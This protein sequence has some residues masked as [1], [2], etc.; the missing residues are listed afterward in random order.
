MESYIH[1]KI[2]REHFTFKGNGH[3]AF[4]CGKIAL[5]KT[6]FLTEFDSCRDYLHRASA[7]NTEMTVIQLHLFLALLY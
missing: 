1:P 7:L 6:D 3:L 2:S 4:H 5:L